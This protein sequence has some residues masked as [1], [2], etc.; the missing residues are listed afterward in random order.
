[1]SEKPKGLRLDF[2]RLARGG[3]YTLG[4]ISARHDECVLIGTVSY[5]NIYAP[6]VK[7]TVSPLDKGSQVSAPSEDRPAVYLVIGRHGPNDR[8]IIPADQE[9]WQPDGRWWM[10]GGNFAD[11][12]DSR[13]DALLP[14]GFAVRVH[15]RHEG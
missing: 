3:D 14:G 2:Y 8:Y 10:H 15:D 5:L 9:T 7:P 4:G 1:M 12:S 6:G 11:S 13:F